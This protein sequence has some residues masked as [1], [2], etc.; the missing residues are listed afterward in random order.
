[1]H[2]YGYSEQGQVGR[3]NDFHLWR[4]ILRY[5][6]DHK[7]GL[8]AAILLSLVV[9]LST[10]M[11]PRLMQYGIDGYMTSAQLDVA[12]RVAGLRTISFAYGFFVCLIFVTNFTQVVL[13]E[14]IAQSVMHRLRQQL[15]GHII[16]L[17]MGFFHKQRAGQ[18]VTRL[19][20]DIQNMHE[21]FTS[22]MVTLFN[23]A[24]KLLG[25]FC[26]LYL[27]NARLALLMTFFIPL[28]FFITRQ[29]A[30]HARETFRRIRS[31]LAK[32][33]SFLA[34][35]LEAISVVQI[36]GRQQWART[37]FTSLTGGYLQ[38]NIEQIKIFGFFMPL[39][40]L[41]SS[42]AV[43][44]ILW[45][46]GGEIIQNRLSLGEL[47]AFLTYMRLF[48]QPLRE[49]SQKY[50]IVQSAMASAERI[51]DVLDVQPAITYNSS[52]GVEK[53]LDGDIHFSGVSFGYSPE[54][55][56]LHN[57]TLHVQQ[58][59]TVAL[60]GTT[61]A[62]KTTL[63]SLLARFY[64]PDTGS[65]TLCGQNIRS[66][67]LTTLRKNIGMIMQDIYIMP[68]TVQE[69][70]VLGELED[71]EKLT[72]ILESTGLNGF[73]G[74]LSNGLQTLIG[75]GGTELSVGEKQLLSFVRALYRDPSVLILDEATSSIDT[76]SENLLEDAIEASFSTRTSLVIAHRLSTVR[77]AD[78][79]V[80]MDQGQIIEQGTHDQLMAYD[81]AYRKLVE[82]D[83]QN[84]Q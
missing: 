19:T 3:L 37:E 47:A 26:F 6:K 58:G 1:M 9:T 22:V 11:L 18:L 13:L 50:S 39:T 67:P 32:I 83:L 60:V 49:L 56:V 51:F 84:G 7:L 45:Y 46:G 66:L 15:F 74:K 30:R 8:I 2:N 43:A 14:W 72:H 80:V 82:I 40:D 81:S 24:L 52:S 10:L 42:A 20:N 21:M 23:D 61:G 12:G 55:P 68:G 75:E 16:R 4:R 79:I 53:K 69:N 27:M 25:I 44:V 54:E 63:I 65:I 34:E 35:T 17:D 41:M 5:S 57:I 59:E 48:F 78:R 71:Q 36:F 70:I 28:A 33:N 73:I 31:Q 64:D 38:R 29:F 77:R 76:E 62:G